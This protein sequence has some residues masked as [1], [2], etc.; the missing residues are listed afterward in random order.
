MDLLN[1]L[2]LSSVVCG[3]DL[4]EKVLKMTRVLWKSF[5]KCLGISSPKQ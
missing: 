3:K 5:R 1:T 4:K 2:E